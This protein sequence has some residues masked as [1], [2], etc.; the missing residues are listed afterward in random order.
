MT[1]KKGLA[2]VPAAARGMARTDAQ[3]EALTLS[4]GAVKVFED[5]LG[6]RERLAAI[7]ATGASD[8]AVEKV[9]NYLLD[10]AY[11][12]MALPRLCSLAGLSVADLFVAFQKAALIRGQ[13]AAASQIEQH[14]G[15]IMADLLRRAQPHDAPC[16]ACGT[17]GTYVPEPSKKQPN[18][19]PEP[20]RACG[21]KGQ[22][23][24]LPDLERQKLVFELADLLKKGGG[25]SISQQMLVATAPAAQSGALE[26]LQ[27]VVSEALYGGGTT[28]SAAAAPVEAEVL[29]AEPVGDV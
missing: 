17:T 16:T 1:P 9:L 13:I 11:A 24:V 25:F 26:Q 23:H 18:P 19:S 29:P 2:L 3:Q 4:A 6:G 5:T 27:Q 14:L 22:V 28:A 7:L 8:P 15:A 10:P 12:A 20:C 21:G